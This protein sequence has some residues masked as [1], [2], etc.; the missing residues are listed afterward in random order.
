MRGP[1]FPG[2]VGFLISVA[3]CL[4]LVSCSRQPRNPNVVLIVVDALRPDFLGCYGFDRPTS[5]NIDSLAGESALF[6]TA[7][8]HASWTK[9]S[10]A[11]FLTSLYPFQHGVVDWEAV[12]SDTIVTL[13][14]ILRSH[15]YHTMSLI[16]M[17]GIAG[18]FNV[19]QGIDERKEYPKYLR[20]AALM[21]DDA[22]DLIGKSSKPFFIMIHYFNTHWPYPAPAKYVD[23]VLKPGETSPIGSSAESYDE[24]GSAPSQMLAER[25]R[26]L[27]SASIRYVD[28]NIGRLVAFLRKAGLERSTVLILTADH[29]EAL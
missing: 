11:S 15:G 25:Q 3:A 18:S 12:M 20:D 28:D 1:R 9:P 14:E 26:L 10:F 5:P 27:Y 2:C 16:T 4:L 17:F 21:T 6:E 29:G 23:L 19:T 8:T 13:P 7:I 22:I 24:E